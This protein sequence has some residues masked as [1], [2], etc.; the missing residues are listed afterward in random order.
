MITRVDS[1]DAVLTAAGEER[2]AAAEGRAAAAC[3]RALEAREHAVRD[4]AAGYEEHRKM[5]RGRGPAA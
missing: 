5:A 1:T 2:A 3:Q 4:A